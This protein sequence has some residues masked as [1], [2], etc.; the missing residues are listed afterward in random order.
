MALALAVVG[1]GLR[2]DD[3]LTVF[4]PHDASVTQKLLLSRLR[5]GP[6]ARAILVAIEG[7]DP[8]VRAAASRWLAKELRSLPGLARVENGAA[9]IDRP[10]IER[11]FAWRYLLGEPGR[12]DRTSLRDALRH[13][14]ASLALPSARSTRTCWRTTRPVSSDV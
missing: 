5:E 3:D 4:L 7:A 9:G 2:I 6:Q 10:G 12:L 14:C 8:A 11:L 13:G 1:Y